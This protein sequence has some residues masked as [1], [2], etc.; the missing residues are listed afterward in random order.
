MIFSHTAR[1][2]RL[3][4]RPHPSSLKPLEHLDLIDENSSKVPEQMFPS[5]LV[6]PL[7]EICYLF[8]QESG[9]GR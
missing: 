4:R 9:S 6:E 2:H 8:L 1:G 5:R 7:S 3:L